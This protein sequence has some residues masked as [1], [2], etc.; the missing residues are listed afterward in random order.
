MTVKLQDQPFLL[1][2]QGFTTESY[3]KLKNSSM[4]KL[5]LLNVWLI[6][7]LKLKDKISKKMELLLMLFMILLFSAKLNK[8]LE[9]E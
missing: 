9:A 2:F 8:P 7:G 4:R 5:E 6:L 1:L 3:K